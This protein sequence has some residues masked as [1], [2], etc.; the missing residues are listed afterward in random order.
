M[1]FSNGG[2]SRRDDRAACSFD[3]DKKKIGCTTSLL[4]TWYSCKPYL[5]EKLAND[6]NKDAIFGRAYPDE[7]RDLML[8]ITAT[9]VGGISQANFSDVVD[10]W[11][12]SDND[13]DKLVGKAIMATTQPVGKSA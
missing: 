13:L 1:D 7:K 8:E 9:T 6:Y 11:A 3:D 5:N 4:Q 12:A 2:T 10:W